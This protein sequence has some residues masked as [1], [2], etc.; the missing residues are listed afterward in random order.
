MIGA[1]FFLVILGLIAWFVN[2]TPIPNPFKTGVL[3]LL[4]IVAIYV[5]AGALGVALPGAHSLR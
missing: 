2:S 1:I 4:I 5:V 3:V